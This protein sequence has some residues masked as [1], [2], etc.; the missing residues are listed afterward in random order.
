MYDRP[1]RGQCGA[2][3]VLVADAQHEQPQSSIV[4]ERRK[5]CVPKPTAHHRH[6]PR[7]PLAHDAQQGHGQHVGKQRQQG[8]TSCQV[9]P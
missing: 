3:G 9:S 1:R 6:A 2:D 5:P 8:N 7:Q 4:D